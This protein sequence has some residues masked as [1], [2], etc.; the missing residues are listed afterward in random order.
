LDRDVRAHGVDAHV[1]DEV[2]EG[3]AEGV[4]FGGEVGGGRWT[5]K[6][7]GSVYRVGCAVGAVLTVV[8]DY[9]WLAPGLAQVCE[10]RADGF[11]LGEVALQEQIV[12][13]AVVGVDGASGWLD[14]IVV[15][16]QRARD[17][18]SC[19]AMLPRATR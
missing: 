9:A 5:K 19:P 10:E 11:G 8:D 4:A 18:S 13:F 16:H 6:E 3:G 15:S 1:G 7:D 14:Q 12:A 17:G 2:V